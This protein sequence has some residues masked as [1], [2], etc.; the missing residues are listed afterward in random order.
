MSYRSESLC[1]RGA[2]TMILRQAP[3]QSPSVVRIS[4]GGAH[5]A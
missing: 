4:Q 5:A 2:D 1:N 3:A